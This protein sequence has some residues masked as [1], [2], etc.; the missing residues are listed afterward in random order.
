MPFLQNTTNITVLLPKATPVGAPN[1]GMLFGKAFNCPSSNFEAW[2]VPLWCILVDPFHR[3]L[4]KKRGLLWVPER[5]KYRLP[6]LACVS[7]LTLKIWF[8]PSPLS[9]TPS[10]TP[11]LQHHYTIITRR[12]LN[13]VTIWQPKA[14]ATLNNVKTLFKSGLPMAH[15]PSHMS[16]GK[17]ILLTF[18]PKKCTMVQTSD[19]SEILSC[20]AQ[21]ITTSAYTVL[22]T[23]LLCLCKPCSILNRLV[24]AFSMFSS[25]TA[26]YSGSHLLPFKLRLP[27]VISYHIQKHYRLITS[28]LF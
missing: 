15:S 16:V 22:L 3:K 19:T 13:G 25:L 2:A 23:A 10:A 20:V 18:S 17:Q 5:L 8:S 9:V 21:A 1:L 12:V 6:T 7:Q 24:L 14:I 27:S 28:G 26:A 11:T 4:S